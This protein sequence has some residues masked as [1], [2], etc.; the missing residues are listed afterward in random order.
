M[1]FTIHVNIWNVLENNTDVLYDDILYFSFPAWIYRYMYIYTLEDTYRCLVPVRVCAH[2]GQEL[3]LAISYLSPT[4]IL[5]PHFPLILEFTGLAKLAGQWGPGPAYPCLPTAAP[6][7]QM[8]TITL[9]FYMG[10]GDQTQ[11][12]VLAQQAFCPPSRH[13]SPNFIF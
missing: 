7:L 5:Q 3:T 12:L 11:V 10:P 4:Y 1:L 6:R 9:G 2:R 8:C 13:P